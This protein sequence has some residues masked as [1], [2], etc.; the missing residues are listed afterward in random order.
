VTAADEFPVRWLQ[1]ETD[2]FATRNP[3]ICADLAQDPCMYEGMRQ[4]F[5]PKMAPL[6]QQTHSCMLVP[7]VA[8]DR[9]VGL[10]WVGHRQPDCYSESQADY[11]TAIALQAAIAIEN[12]HHVQ[13]MQ[14]AAADQERNRLAQELH[15][16]VSQTLLTA[17]RVA[18]SLPDLW[19]QSPEQGR[20]ALRQV[21]HM[22]QSSLAEMRTLMLE[23]RPAILAQKPL[24][25]I[26]RQLRDGFASRS[27]L[28][29]QLHDNG[30]A[31]L[32]AI[33]QVFFYRIAQGALDNIQQHAQASQVTI[34]L[35]CLPNY[36]EMRIADD[37]IG[38]DPDTVSAD[39]MGLAIMRERAEK[40]GA[41]LQV[42]SKPGQGTQIKIRY[43][44]P[45][46]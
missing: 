6:L 9:V 36:V 39:R 14:T 41:T 40:I 30:D 29:V 44:Y 35:N 38:F 34:E 27:Q 43:D 18:E 17:N 23:L 11:V 12:A 16:S 10:L 3:L 15:D 13:A 5:G 19:D 8:R 32:P 45:I 37:G 4:T 7:M 28:P 31:I 21:H 1:E 33:C 2:L 42:D 26:L 20:Y 25:E 46:G 24:G 22:L